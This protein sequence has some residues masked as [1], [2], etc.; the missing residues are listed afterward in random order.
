M[1]PRPWGGLLVAIFS[2]R[3]E[4]KEKRRVHYSHLKKRRELAQAKG[5]V[6]HLLF[7]IETRGKNWRTD[8]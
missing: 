2:E 8:Q 4:R 1:S 7:K 3:K 6:S 5:R